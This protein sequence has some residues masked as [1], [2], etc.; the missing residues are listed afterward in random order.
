MSWKE[1]A[2]TLLSVYARLRDIPPARLLEILSEWEMVERFG[3]SADHVWADEWTKAVARVERRYQNTKYR[4]QATVLQMVGGVWWRAF[5]L[6]EDDPDEAYLCPY[7]CRE[8]SVSV[9]P[10]IGSQI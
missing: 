9:A 4:P 5:T 10:A 8:H 3:D 7:G 1:D 6:G 2:E